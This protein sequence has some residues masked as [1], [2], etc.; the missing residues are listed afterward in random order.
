M[1]VKTAAL[2]G[3]LGGY[4]LEIHRGSTDTFTHGYLC[5]LMS[6]YFTLGLIPV[7]TYVDYPVT[8]LM[9]GEF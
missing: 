6:A 9:K 3:L 4:L 2:D 7:Q 5:G 1:E 8:K